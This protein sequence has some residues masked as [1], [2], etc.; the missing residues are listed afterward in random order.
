MIKCT[1]CGTLN[2]DGTLLC[3]GCA[4][5]VSDAPYVPDAGGGA[6]P[7]AEPA[8]AEPMFAEPMAAEPMAAEPFA[9]PFAEPMQAEPLA[10]E[11]SMDALGMEEVSSF[12]LAENTLPPSGSFD[13]TPAAPSM[14]MGSPPGS[15]PSSSK[16]GGGVPPGGSKL[17]GPPSPGPN[18][19][20]A[21]KIPPPASPTVLAPPDSANYPPGP[22]GS[23]VLGGQT[24]LRPP[25]GVRPPTGMP[26]TSQ[27]RPPTAMPPTSQLRPPTAVKPPTSLQP[28][29]VRP[30]TVRQPTQARPPAPRVSTL[31]PEDRPKLVVVVGMKKDVAY[32]V[33]DGDN[34][35][36]R[37]D[38]TPVDI[39]VG[40]QEAEDKIRCSRQHALVNYDNGQM[41]IQ[42]LN[43]ANGTYI[44]RVRLQPNEKRRIKH[45]D[46]IQTG[47]VMF[48]V[49]TT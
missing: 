21:T 49:R 24:G 40:D 17:G 7:A 5:D 33:Y 29:A 37:A 15:P 35:I 20:K 11:S 46:Y 13:V 34:F 41:F 18:P 16:L 48:V 36:G 38:E 19:N 6:A 28:P 1:N 14:V 25:T 22:P 44:N 9:E 31:A 43:S 8:Q 3:E 45:G 10:A 32:P 23:T 12:E 39:D 26:P 47:G 27:V 2:I 30:P 4:W 42:D